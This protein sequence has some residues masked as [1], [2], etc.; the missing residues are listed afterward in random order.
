MTT[1]TYNT[2]DKPYDILPVEGEPNKFEIVIPVH[3]A[4]WK[5][6]DNYDP[7][8]TVD[9][10]GNR[11]H[12]HKEGVDALFNYDDVMETFADAFMAGVEWM[13]KMEK[14]KKVKK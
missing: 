3:K 5:A 7:D 1:K 9:S 8:Y 6:W 12:L 14:K 13:E 2:D 4:L 11:Q 10:K